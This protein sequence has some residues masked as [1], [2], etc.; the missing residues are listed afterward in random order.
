M[1]GADIGKQ[2][3]A[4]TSGEYRR[5][6]N[7]SGPQASAGNYSATLDIGK[8]SAAGTSG[9]YRRIVTATGTPPLLVTSSDSFKDLKRLLDSI[10]LL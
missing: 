4:G 10:R 6:S 3:A 5:I 8:Q 1:T 7:A 2:V 9:D